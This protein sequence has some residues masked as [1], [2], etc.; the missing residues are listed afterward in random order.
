LKKIPEYGLFGTEKYL[1]E[2]YGNPMPVV[3]EST[4]AVGNFVFWR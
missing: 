1:T 3:Q 2:L 4:P